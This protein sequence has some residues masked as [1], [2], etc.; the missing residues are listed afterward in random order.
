MIRENGYYWVKIRYSIKNEWE[1]AKW[2]N[3]S[4]HGGEFLMF[5]GKTYFDYELDINESRIVLGGKYEK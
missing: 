1:I 5:H 2:D 4:K 3:N